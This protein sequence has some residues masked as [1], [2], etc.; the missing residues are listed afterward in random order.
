MPSLQIVNRLTLELRLLVRRLAALQLATKQVGVLVLIVSAVIA[1]PNEQA[2]AAAI[3]VGKNPERAD[4]S[5]EQELALAMRRME[6]T[7]QLRHSQALKPAAVS[8]QGLG[9]LGEQTEFIHEYFF[10][11]MYQEYKE[12]TA[13]AGGLAA[14]TAPIL[15][16]GWSEPRVAEVETALQEMQRCR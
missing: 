15:R 16:H 10:D 11:P 9:E 7:G 12:L 8:S 5:R 2:C 4:V 6:R 1:L 14:A 13:A 3:C